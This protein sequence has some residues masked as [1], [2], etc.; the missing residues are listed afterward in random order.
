M[1]SLPIDNLTLV[2]RLQYWS[3]S[4]KDKRHHMQQSVAR[5]AHAALPAQ[6]SFMPCSRSNGDLLMSMSE[7]PIAR[8]HHMQ[9]SVARQAHVALPAQPLCLSCLR[10]SGD[11]LMPIS[12]CPIVN[13]H[14]MQ[15][16]VARQAS[17]SVKLHFQLSP[18]ACLALAAT[19]TF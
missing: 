4:P 1:T 2:K 5:Q 9:Q 12:E 14:H 19:E 6:C 10:S 18:Y 8:R 11:L 17:A 7:C 13:R 3:K 15:Q 16:S